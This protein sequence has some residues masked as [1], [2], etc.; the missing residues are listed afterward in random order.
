MAERSE[1]EI[2]SGQQC[3]ELIGT[4]KVS[5]PLSTNSAIASIAVDDH[6]YENVLIIM[7]EHP[8]GRNDCGKL[9]PCIRPNELV[10]PGTTSGRRRHFLAWLL[11][12]RRVA[13]RWGAQ[14]QR[15]CD[16]AVG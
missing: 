10:K 11:Q 4:S 3:G 15:G 6:R 1:V 9:M 8:F 13:R 12:T 14:R 5:Y 16:R 7:S 2:S